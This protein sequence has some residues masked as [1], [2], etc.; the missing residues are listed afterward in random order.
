M[1]CGIGKL[2]VDNVIKKKH[3]KSQESMSWRKSDVLLSS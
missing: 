2:I 3:N 1:L